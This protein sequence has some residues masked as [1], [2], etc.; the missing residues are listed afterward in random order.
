MTVI[1]CLSWKTA[2][3]RHG[4]WCGETWKM[5]RSAGPT[6]GHQATVLSTGEFRKSESSG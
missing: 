3:H 1:R 5:T 2:P 4:R 6:D